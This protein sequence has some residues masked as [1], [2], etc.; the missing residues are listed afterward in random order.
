[1][2]I[3]AGFNSLRVYHVSVQLRCDV[4]WQNNIAL[5][6]NTRRY[7]W[8]NKG[9]LTRLDAW[10]VFNLFDNEKCHRYMYFIIQK[11]R[12]VVSTIDV[13]ISVYQEKL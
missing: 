5:S 1:M 9:I 7:G 13:H 10:R 6:Q 8:F 2:A 11:N 12:S 3:S 4:S